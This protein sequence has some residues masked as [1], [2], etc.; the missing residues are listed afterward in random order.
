MRLHSTI[1]IIA[2]ILEVSLISS[3]YQNKLYKA[4]VEYN[5]LNYQKAAG[6]YEGL[7]NK[8]VDATIYSKLGDSYRMM[9]QLETAAVWYQKSYEAGKLTGEDLYRYAQVLKSLKRYEE[10]KKMYDEYLIINPN[11][12][13]AK[14]QRNSI[15]SL[16]K[17][18]EGSSWWE[19]RHLCFNESYSNFSAT[20]YDKGIAFCS[21]RNES[22]K[23][24]EWNG[25]PYLNLYHATFDELG[26]PCKVHSLGSNLDGP[27]HEG[28]PVFADGYKTIYYTGNVLD[29][30]G[31]LVKNEKDENILAL[32]KA[33]YEGDNWTNIERLSFCT[34]QYSCM[35]P[36]LAADQKTLYFVSDMPGGYGG[37]D[38]YVVRFENGEWGLPQ[39]LGAKV[40]TRENESFPTYYRSEEGIE[41]LYFSS[42]GRAGMGGMDIYYVEVTGGKV[43]GDVKHLNAPINSEGDDFG[44]LWKEY[45]MSGYLSSSR[46]SRSGVDNIY[47]F[48]K[49]LPKYYL[50]VKVYN[51]SSGEP[52]EG[53]QVIVGQIS[54]SKQ[55][56]EKTDANG[57]FIIEVDSNSIF[58]LESKK[59]MY[60]KAFGTA[61]TQ[62]LRKTDTVEATLY[63]DP[64]VIDK[65]IRLDNIY[66]DYNKWDIRPD[67]AIELDKLVKIMQENPEINI[68]LSSHT[69]SRGKDKYNMTLS[70]NR[71]QSAVNYIISKGID[72]SR[73]YAKGYGESK[74]LN[75][76]GNGV[77]CSEEEHQ[78]NRRTE[79]KVVKIS[80]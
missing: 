48:Q 16:S 56:S 34:D 40:N 14:W 61:S 41:Y 37:T 4:N 9:N 60:F 1:G 52:V 24:S 46:G 38:L 70:Q 76:C 39:N 72:A 79:F 47:Y 17:Y 13:S 49:N 6:M 11:N 69:D 67:A 18:M 22:G 53:A 32:Y 54:G 66:Y 68:E 35:H 7:L 42:T 71:A 15:D 3:C 29:T 43:K 8:K 31:R 25:K 80:Q 63:M 10:S 58:G 20:Y 62:G 27:Y 65:A 21:D 51:K 23:I 73:I 59:E 33:N 75:R 36:A 78:L 57:A 12:E 30:K 2:M 55:Y 26:E 45:E 19:I 5:N 44:L 74:L 64:I 28:T 50:R 77:Q